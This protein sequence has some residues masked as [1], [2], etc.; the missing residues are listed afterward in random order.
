MTGVEVRMK[1]RMSDSNMLLVSLLGSAFVAVFATLAANLF[2]PIHISIAI[3]SGML[4]GQLCT[5]HLW[6]TIS[7]AKFGANFIR[8]IIVFSVYVLTTLVAAQASLLAG[9][10]VLRASLLFVSILSCLSIVLGALLRTLGFR[11]ANAIKSSDSPA[12]TLQFTLAEL[13][14]LTTVAGFLVLN[15]AHLSST[16]PNYGFGLLIFERSVTRGCIPFSCV[17]LGVFLLGMRQRWPKRHIAIL[18]C[19]LSGW[20]L[21]GLVLTTV[22]PSMIWPMGWSFVSAGVLSAISIAVLFRFLG[23][24]LHLCG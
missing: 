17:V 14:V 6:A 7:A 22:I 11:C 24:R 1:R 2:L 20:S 19:F 21:T 13:F 9:I 18:M 16:D 5:Y 10:G 3:A 23:W 15:T 8:H 4:A 12:I